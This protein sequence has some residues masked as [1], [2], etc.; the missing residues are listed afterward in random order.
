MLSSPTLS[1]MSRVCHRLPFPVTCQ[2]TQGPCSLSF[3][4][5][6]KQFLSTLQSTICPRFCCIILQKRP[7]NSCLVQT[8]RA[9][10]DTLLA[11]DSEPWLVGYERSTLQQRPPTDSPRLQ[12]FCRSRK[13]S[14]FHSCSILLLPLSTTLQPKPIPRSAADAVVWVCN[15]SP[16]LH[17]IA[18]T[19][20]VCGC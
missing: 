20:Y 16:N 7:T 12:T 19:R 6:H 10:L 11:A 5:L 9:L 4:F 14:N 18:S 2:L 8:G 3:Q 15:S 13:L 1:L 17:A